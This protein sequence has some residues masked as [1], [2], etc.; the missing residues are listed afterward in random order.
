MS[1]LIANRWTPIVLL[2][3]SDVFMTFAWYGHL[4]FKGV[5][6]WKV[7]LASWSI[8]FC[9][10]VLMV[11]ANRWGNAAYSATELKIIQEVISLVV[12]CCFAVTYLGEKLH[13]NHI[14]LSCAFWLRWVSR[15]FRNGNRSTNRSTIMPKSLGKLKA[16][17]E[18]NDA[19][20]LRGLLERQPD[21]KR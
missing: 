5:P 18:K 12:F 4:K 9:E 20:L 1:P 14:A 2:V 13:W 7:I 3:C 17:F 21:I 16:A 19:A 6:L 8:A 10:Y 15:L 11:P